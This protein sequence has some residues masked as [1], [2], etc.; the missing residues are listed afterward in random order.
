MGTPVKTQ[1]T[2]RWK[3]PHKEI[4]PEERKVRLRQ[5]EPLVQITRSELQRLM[6]E[7]GRNALV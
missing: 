2:S 7:A 5:V 4:H 1:I 3:E 6:E